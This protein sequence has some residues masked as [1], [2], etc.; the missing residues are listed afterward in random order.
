M[1]NVT[2]TFPNI[3]ELAKFH[4]GYNGPTLHLDLKN[5]SLAGEMPDELISQ[6][7]ANHHALL[8]INSKDDEGKFS[9]KL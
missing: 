9:N 7:T 2:L 3:I 8:K 4:I 5:Y 6:A 1:K